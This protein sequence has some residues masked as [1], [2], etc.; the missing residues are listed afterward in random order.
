MAFQLWLHPI[1]FGI[2]YFYLCL[3]QDTFWFPFSYLFWPTGCSVNVLDF[4]IFVILKI[5]LFDFQF[6]IIVIRKYVWCD[7]SLLK[8]VELLCGLIYDLSWRMFCGHLRR[9][10]ILLWMGGMFYTCLLYPF[11]LYCYSSLRFL[12]R[13]VSEW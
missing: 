2:L 4:H 11:D 9:M 13:F 7:F 6:H 10:Y 1:W 8:L 5:F 12:I 3:S